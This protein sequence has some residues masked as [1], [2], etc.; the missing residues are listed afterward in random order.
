MTSLPPFRDILDARYGRLCQAA[1]ARSA[2]AGLAAFRARGLRLVAVFGW[3]CTA[4]FVLMAVVIPLH[5]AAPAIAV[6][7]LLSGAATLGARP[8]Q[9]G[10][11][12][13]VPAALMA[14]LQPA[15]LVF[16]LQEHPWQMEAHMYF[17][18]G[19]TALGLLSDWRPLAVAAVT[20]LS[21]HLLLGYFVP[22]ATFM[23][24]WALER[25]LIHAGAVL[26]VVMLASQQAALSSRLLA[27]EEHA[28]ADSE[29][30]AEQAICARGD[31]ETAL[32]A[33]CAAERQAQVER[34]RHEDAELN[35]RRLRAE[36]ML[37]LGHRF[38]T[39]V[40]GVVAAVSEAAAQLEQSART[41][42]SFAQ[43]TGELTSDVVNQATSA[44]Q[45]A[46]LVSKAVGALSRSIA[47]VAN[48]SS[49]QSRLGTIAR[50]ST[51][52]GEKSLRSLAERAANVGAC[53]T[54]IKGVAA[55]TNLLA[56]NATIESAR[57]GEAG[58]GFAVVANEVKILASKTRLATEEVT[59]LVSTIGCGA[60]Q[61]DV[62]L[63]EVASAMAS[64]AKH[65]EQVK[66]E[67]A[68]QRSTALMIER[69][70][71]ESAFG[72]SLMSERFT[73][74]AQAASEASEMS[75]DVQQSASRLANI[76][77]DLEGATNQFIAQLR[78]A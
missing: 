19:L 30:A 58:R 38:E 65:A 22:A 55:Q 48:S 51:A 25:V 53:I 34:E 26:L 61:A 71:E 1:A 70:A 36:A 59:E 32:A 62:A 12:N 8:R 74:V 14:A 52:E 33:T 78:A 42:N 29:I 15:V 47:S 6:S 3:A 76:A 66:V 72:V 27:D 67:V 75:G 54:L 45:T 17:F 46:G 11:R 40:A 77:K 56:L 4:M 10:A 7:A 41:M 13:Y 73:V 44:S 50:S 60:H 63:A 16:L 21:H 9:Y 35:A 57:A 39:S 20:I 37:S 23:G 2:S 28:R 69:T 5:L 68:S 49:E 31:A 24:G 18:V 64:L 43:T